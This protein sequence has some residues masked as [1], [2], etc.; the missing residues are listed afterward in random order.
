MADTIMRAPGP[1]NYAFNMQSGNQVTITNSGNGN[2]FAVLVAA[3][4]PADFNGLY[5]LSGYAETDAGHF[6]TTIANAT[7]ISVAKSS[8]SF[9]IK[10]ASGTNGFR[11]ACTVLV[12]DNNALSF[13]FS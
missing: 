9:V 5:L 3:T 11:I 1:R 6:I 13:A 7:K 12:D 4:G 10:H 8:G 2:V